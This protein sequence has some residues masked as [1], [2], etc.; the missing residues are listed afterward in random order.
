MAKET[1]MVSNSPE[2]RA[3]FEHLAAGSG[4]TIL[5]EP[6]DRPY[7][8]YLTDRFRKQNDAPVRITSADPDDPAVIAELGFVGRENVTVEGVVFDSSGTKRTQNH[9]DLEITDSRNITVTDSAFQGDA[10]ETLDGSKGQTKGVIMALVR[11]SDDVALRDNTVQGYYHGIAFKDSN[12][13]EFTGNEMTR[14]QGDAIRIAGAQD[15]LVEGNHLHSMLGSAQNVNHSD[16]IQFWGTHIDQNIERVT[17]RGNLINTGD[18]PAYQMI[19][20][21]NQDRAENGW[22]FED[23]VIEGNLLHG[24]HHNMIAIADTR[25]MVVRDNTVLW[26]EDSHLIE[27]GGA[28]GAN[29]N[30]WI[31]ALH[32]RGTV[33][34]GNIATKIAGATGPNATV[35]YRDPSKESHHSR[36]FVNLGAGDTAELQDLSLLP[37]SP[38][39]GKRGAPMSWSSHRVEDITAVVT[40]E[41]SESD[42]SVVT[43]DAS[44]SRDEGG[45]LGAGASYVWSFADGSTELGQTVTHDFGTAGVKEYALEVRSGGRSDRIERTIEIEDPSLLHLSAKGGR[46]RDVSSYDSDL[47]VKGGKVEDGGFVLDGSSKIMVDRDSAQ[48]YS[49]DQFAL[50]MSFDPAS[51]GAFGV[52]F[53]LRE[54]MQGYVRPDGA[55]KFSITT[56]EGEAVAV[57]RARRVLGRQGARP[58]GDLRRARGHDPRRRR[59]G[60]ARPP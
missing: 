23:I 22:L 8:A 40:T 41:R 4:G 58:G 54:A 33:I 37:G 9:R 21:T 17:I 32:S 29:S 39:D 16:M 46:V 12:D 24:A 50:T 56:T 35:T 13:V 57:D 44:L 30:G 36:N 11:D 34:E 59:G 31:R 10:T 2:L 1:I 7:E 42:R 47:K 15:L 3:A 25:D 5:L 60:R 26:A 55:F 53:V 28:Q 14:L 38:W 51:K 52:L 49:L 27:S 48:I 19:F 18:G 6:S 43:L 20:G 45:R